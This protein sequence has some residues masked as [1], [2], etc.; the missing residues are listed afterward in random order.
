MNT[1]T[2]SIELIG[3]TKVAQRVDLYP[4]AVQKWRDLGRLPRTELAGLTQ[5]AREISLLS[6]ETG[7]PVTVDQ[8]LADTRTAWE[9]HM[10][11]S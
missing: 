7:E 11:A 6:I 1:V 10:E 9:A 8:L 5:Y 2:R 3:T 4:S